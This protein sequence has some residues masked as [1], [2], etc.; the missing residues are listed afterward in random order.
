MSTAYL[1]VQLWK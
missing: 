1:V